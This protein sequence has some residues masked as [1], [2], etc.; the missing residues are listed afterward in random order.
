MAQ[1]IKLKRSTSPGSSPT[2]SDLSIGELA[3]NVDDGKVFLR[4]SGSQGDTVQ[5]L[6]GNIYTGSIDV[7]GSI[8]ASYFVGDGSRL[9]NITVEQSATIKR[10]FSNSS[11]WVVNHNLDTPNAIVQVYDSN[12]FQVIPATLKITNNDTVTITFPQAESGYVVVAKGGHVVSGSIPAT[13]VSGLS[14]EIVANLPSGLISGSSQ[15]VLTGDVTGTASSSSINQI[16]GGS[17]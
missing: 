6:V 8:S 7:T 1:I 14:A 17:I 11:T 12:D 3:I 4:R 15:V 2:T 5:E 13:N 10:T 9:E 16:D